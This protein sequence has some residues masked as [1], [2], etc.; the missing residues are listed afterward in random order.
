MSLRI[1]LGFDFLEHLSPIYLVAWV[2]LTFFVFCFLIQAHSLHFLS[3]IL[4][5]E[6][7]SLK[8]SLS[9]SCALKLLFIFIKL[10]RYLKPPIDHSVNLIFE[11]K[12]LAFAYLQ[13]Y[14]N[15]FFPLNAKGM[16]KLELIYFWVPFWQLPYFE[17]FL[18]W[19]YQTLLLTLFLNSI[20]YFKKT[21]IIQ[22]LMGRNSKFPQCKICRQFTDDLFMNLRIYLNLFILLCHSYSLRA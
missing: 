4:F 1:I 6:K 17:D 14:F 12:T 10:T 18:H 19:N 9:K 22:E 11:K 7:I 16:S 13:E 5:I 3:I 20:Q 2:S 21:H 8:F 15:I